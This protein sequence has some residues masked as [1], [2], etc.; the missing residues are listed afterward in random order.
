MINTDN[1]YL[2]TDEQ[3]KELLGCLLKAHDAHIKIRENYSSIDP[4]LERMLDIFRD[5]ESMSTAEFTQN[6]EQSIIRYS[7]D[8]EVIRKELEARNVD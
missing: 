1:M 5:P 4:Q 2:A 8:I 7:K 3:L 6:V